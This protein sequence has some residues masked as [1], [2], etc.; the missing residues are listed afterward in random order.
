[1]QGEESLPLLHQGILKGRLGEALDGVLGVV[2]AHAHP[3]PVKL[4]HLPLA[5]LAPTLRG[6]HQ[7][8][9]ARLCHMQVCRPVLVTKGVP[10]TNSG[11]L[12]GVG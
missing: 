4:V 10:G 7:L 12:E 5:L 8:Q 11:G 6:E 1:M 9:L 2:H 3:C